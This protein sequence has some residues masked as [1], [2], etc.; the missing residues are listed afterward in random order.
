MSLGIPVIGGIKSGGMPFTLDHGKAGI[1]VDI[2]SPECV[3]DAMIRLVKE[4]E[5]C[6]NLAMAARKYAQRNFHMNRTI[7][8][9]LELYCGIIE[10]LHKK[11]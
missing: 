7:N 11:S 10:N 9:Y 5:L 1:L 3:A 2:R 8:S 4:P 6:S